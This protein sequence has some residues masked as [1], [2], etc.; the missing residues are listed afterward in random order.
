MQSVLV[1]S[2]LW[3]LFGGSHV[4]LATSR[5]RQALVSRAGVQGF[6]WIFAVIA[7]LSFSALV[8]GYSQVRFTGP[9]GIGL[10]T[11]SW[12]RGLLTATSAAGVV[13][14][15]GALA[16]S[17]YWDS[18]GA[19]FVQGVRPAYGLE[20]VTRH[21]FFAGTVLTMGSHALLATHMTGTIFFGGFVVLAVVGPVHQARKLSARKGEAFARYLASTSAIPFVAIVRGRQ[22]LALRE[23]PWPA[24]AL[25]VLIAFGV[26][27]LHEGIF[28]WYGAPFIVAVAGGGLLIGVINM[29]RERRRVTS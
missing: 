17:G 22:P 9:A 27:H 3:L 2:G 18:P 12:G 23:L 8:A 1:V 20:R 26:R 14:M 7:A 28:A 10:T 5:V 15:I 16:P 6:T 4:G 25:G 24:L 29:R 11:T 19:V 21:P 13:F